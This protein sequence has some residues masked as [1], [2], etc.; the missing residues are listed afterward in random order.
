M[1]IIGTR[2]AVVS[3]TVW[4]LKMPVVKASDICWTETDLETIG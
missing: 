1:P 2:I 3:F 4:L